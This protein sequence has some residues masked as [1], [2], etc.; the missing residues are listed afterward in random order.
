MKKSLTNARGHHSTFS[1]ITCLFSFMLTSLYRHVQVAWDRA[2]SPATRLPLRNARVNAQSISSSISPSLSLVVSLELHW[3][4]ELKDNAK[5]M[6][7]RYRLLVMMI[8]KIRPLSLS[9]STE[10]EINVTLSPCTRA[11]VFS[12]EPVGQMFIYIHTQLSISHIQSTLFFS[13]FT[14][15]VDGCGGTAISFFP[16]LLSPFSFDRWASRVWSETKSAIRTISIY[17]K[18]KK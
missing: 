6:P 3:V 12:A 11:C 5:E 8:F 9:R 15:Y 7:R 16:P 1:S 18:E 13:S 17:Q 10:L 14:F 4:N 2:A